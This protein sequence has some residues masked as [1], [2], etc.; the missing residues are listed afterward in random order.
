MQTFSC[1][2]IMVAARPECATADAFTI[3]GGEKWSNQFET[4]YAASEGRFCARYAR[5]S[6]VE[7]KR[8]VLGGTLAAVV[9]RADP[10]ARKLKALLPRRAQGEPAAEHE[11]RRERR[12]GV[13]SGWLGRLADQTPPASRAMG[14]L[15]GLTEFLHTTPVAGWCFSCHGVGT[16]AHYLALKIRWRR[17]TADDGFQR[18]NMFWWMKK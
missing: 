18:K 15:T 10:L 9:G 11:R 5:A 17:E 1:A 7:M 4:H 8:S 14:G 2:H 13:S 6:P 16:C 3:L 12:R